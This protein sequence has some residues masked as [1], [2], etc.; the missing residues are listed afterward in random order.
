MLHWTCREIEIKVHN[1]A[2]CREN[3]DVHRVH[4][5]IGIIYYIR[6]Y[7]YL[8]FITRIPVRIE[9]RFKH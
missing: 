5:E 8:L 4:G 3:F 2:H 9:K 1:S 7:L 6:L